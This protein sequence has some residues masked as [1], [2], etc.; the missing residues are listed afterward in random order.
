M[1]KAIAYVVFLSMWGCASYD[2]EFAEILQQEDR[3]ASIQE[4]LK[5]SIH[6]SWQVQR[7]V[8]LA[9][10]RL[11]DPQ[12]APTLVN[13]LSS[14]SPEVRVEAAFALG[15]LAV[16][17][18]YEAILKLL[19]EEKDL[20][21]RLTLIEALSKVTVDSLPPS[22][23]STFLALLD[24]DIPIVRAEAALA[25]GR[26]AH[27]NIKLAHWSPKLTP[28]LQ[29]KGE[30]VRWRAAYAL[31][32]LADSS[33]ATA[34]RSAL[35][36]RSAR[37]RMQAARALNGMDD[38]AALPALAK[39]A[40]ADGDWRVRVNAAAALGKFNFTGEAFS[41]QSFPLQ[42][43]DLHVRIAALRALG[44]AV[45]RM[46]KAHANF[47]SES[48][49]TFLLE[50]LVTPERNGSIHKSW[51]EKAAAAH[52]LAQLLQREALPF[53]L[54]LATETEPHLRAALANALVIT[55]SE[56][57]LPVL[58]VLASDPHT[59]VRLAVLEALPKISAR[60]RRS[61]SALPIYLNALNSGDHVLA[62]LAAQN[63]A[64]DSTQRYQHAEAIIAAHHK[65]GASLDAETAQ[66]IFKALAGCGNPAAQPLLEAALQTPD[67][68]LA[69]AAAE[70][71]K[72]LTGK[73]Y[74]EH[75]PKLTAPAQNY[76][77]DE[78]K[79]LQSAWAEVRTELG[80]FEIAFLP[81]EAPLTVLN[82]VRLAQK[83]FF[84]GQALHRVV[85]NFVVQ[86]GDPRGDGWGGPGY[87][88]RSEFNRL[89]YVRGMV[90]MA[91]AG[92]D[93]EGSQWFVTHSDQPHLDGRYTIFARVRKGMD[94][95][96]K[97]QI[98]HHIVDIKIHH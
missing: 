84:D 87:A 60:S 56:E 92:K 52:A 53:L 15:Q 19:S 36:D 59:M 61:E 58:E 2:K 5:Y 31:M 22:S 94:L 4:A 11:G 12:A 67:K 80:A 47:E 38:A 37:V 32:R 25:L 97:L 8:A 72:Q 78:I 16:P 91:S 42:D 69:R 49:K 89:R 65:L 68:A 45:E 26:L 88:I 66:I 75:L 86:T 76:S 46:R 85:P 70:A 77:Y 35:D 23:D 57:A 93:T 6:P 27:R 98:G 73:D 64:A 30:E 13:M 40:S 7:R 34:L 10:G 14:S 33:S 95:V 55:E 79:S 51:H 96:D 9:L 54:P 20:E 17:S 90:G 41:L 28:L 50:Q 71:L 48:V 1:R 39:T 43:N 81:E 74:T 62:A 18:T 3:R 83:N 24:D 29:D 44:E 21:V 82:F 63:L